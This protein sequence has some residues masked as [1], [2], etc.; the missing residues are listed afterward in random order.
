M[1]LTLYGG[2]QKAF[3]SNDLQIVLTEGKR[4]R[5]GHDHPEPF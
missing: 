5:L 3:R 4:L 1:P 2:F